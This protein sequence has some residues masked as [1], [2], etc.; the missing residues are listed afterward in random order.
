[1]SEH[2]SLVRALDS[3]AV[4][5]FAVAWLSLRAEPPL[6]N[7]TSRDLA[8]ARDL[9]DGAELHLHGAWASFGDLVQGTAWIDL[10]A[11]CMRAGL[12]LLGIH[13][14]LTLLLAAAVALMHFGVARLLLALEPTASHL[15]ARGGPLA[16]AMVLLAL[17][18][19]ACELPIL[20][21]PTL[22]P[23]AVVF[24]HL[25]LWRLLDSGELLDGLALGLFCALAL[26]IHVIAVLCSLLLLLATPLA[27]KRP[28]LT[29]CAS[30]AVLFGYSS[31]TSYAALSSNYVAASEHGWVG[32]GVLIGAGVI[33]VGLLLRSRFAKLSL[34][35]RLELAVAFEAGLVLVVLLASLLPSTPEV[36]GRYLLPFAPALAL[37]VALVIA[38]LGAS[39]R[40]TM[41]VV[42]VA[43]LL[44]LASFPRLRQHSR[45]HLPLLPSFAQRDIEQLAVHLNAAGHT[46]AELVMRLQGPERGPVLGG[47]TPWIDD[48]EPSEAMPERGLLLL[49][50]AH[51]QVEALL[52]ELPASTQTIAL[53]DRTL[54]LI[55]TAARLDR[56]AALACASA[57]DCKPVTVV[58]PRRV[59]KAY[60]K[61]WIGAQVL[62]GWLAEREQ[63]RS[64][65]RIPVRPG[66]AVTLMLPFAREPG[67]EWQILEAKGLELSQSSSSSS[68]SSLIEL[69]ADAEGELL[70]AREPADE[71]CGGRSP[72]PPA[73]YELDPSWTRLRALLLDHVPGYGGGSVGSG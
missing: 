56:T 26:D 6:H 35:A 60:P 22:L 21:Q 66:P 11:L 8:F 9:V 19:A 20:W 48:G 15:T 54:L 51:E 62:A 25:A 43:A 1:M 31:L 58:V 47:L 2:R 17:L 7:D 14:V 37:L 69:P 72:L 16:S 10:L 53:D 33:G 29:T 44:L 12:G 61:S 63:Q 32:P 65:W 41:A 5:V 71:H 68:S 40:A 28:L 59:T 67:C 64:M 24:V 27:A 45:Q 46:W 23:I 18:P 73:P 36:T 30:V 50:V 34:R 42:G 39:R 57:Q 38:R 55:E 52:D 70:L 49:A 4:F 13:H 3:L